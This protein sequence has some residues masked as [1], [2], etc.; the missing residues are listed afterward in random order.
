MRK[1][2]GFWL[3]IALSLPVVTGCN[4]AD[5]KASERDA[6]VQK[7]RVELRAE[8]SDREWAIAELKAKLGD[9]GPE[10]AKTRDL[11]IGKWAG[12]ELDKG[13]R[14]T[15]DFTRD[16][17]STET[18]KGGSGG[19]DGQI[20]GPYLWLDDD[21]IAVGLSANAEGRPKEKHKVVVTKDDLTLTA[22]DGNPKK[23]KRVN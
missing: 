20:I 17:K 6:E 13:S 8:V 12:V 19:L 15:L 14:M 9:P 23:Y 3:S 11:L 10:A 5:P 1:K 21:H 18:R 4:K 16:G 2:V 7:L 22:A